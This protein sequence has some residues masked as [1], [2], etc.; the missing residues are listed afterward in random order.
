MIGFVKYLQGELSYEGKII[1]E[2]DELSEGQN[3]IQEVGD[4]KTESKVL[5]IMVNKIRVGASLEEVKRIFTTDYEVKGGNI[6]GNITRTLIYLLDED[7]TSE[8]SEAMKYKEIM[9]VWK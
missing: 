4:K 7:G 2:I 6:T 8:C 5:E 3:V 9:G 1:R